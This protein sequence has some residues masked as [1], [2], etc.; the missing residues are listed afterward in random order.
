MWPYMFYI[1]FY[2]LGNIYIYI[3][4]VSNV[5][6]CN[7]YYFHSFIALFK[8]IQA[9]SIEKSKNDEKIQFIYNSDNWIFIFRQLKNNSQNE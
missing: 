2:K 5:E 1:N 7:N 3:F 8:E 9:L 6:S 4:F